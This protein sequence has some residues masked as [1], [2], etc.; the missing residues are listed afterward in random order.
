V[1][2]DTQT[3]GRTALVFMLAWAFFDAE[4]QSPQLRV[5]R[6]PHPQAE[7]R[8]A[9]SHPATAPQQRVHPARRRPR[10]IPAPKVA[11]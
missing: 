6:T 9:A 1:M 10:P 3:I 2:M 11:K 7:S 8:K 4:A 5:S